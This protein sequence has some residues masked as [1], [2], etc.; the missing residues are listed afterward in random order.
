MIIIN[1]FPL[2]AEYFRAVDGFLNYEVSTDG[3]VR[4]SKTGR[5]LKAGVNSTRHLRVCL[6][7]DRQ[8][9]FM[10]VHRLVATAFCN[11]E[12]NY[13]VVDHIDRNPS[14]NNYHNLRWSTHSE[15][16]RNKSV[17]NTNTSGYPGVFHD[18]TKDAWLASWFGNI[19]TRH[20]KCF[21]V[22]I[23]GNEQAKQMAIYHR[24][25]WL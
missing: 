6:S 25:K 16:S 24:K 14:N 17:H 18:R 22:K 10:Y 9:S 5:I 3:R 7:K 11:N 23:H 1:D 2:N 19:K 20:R 13:N 8:P 4:N 15:N 21:S 12:N